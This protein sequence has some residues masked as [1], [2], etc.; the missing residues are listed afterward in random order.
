MHCDTNNIKSQESITKLKNSSKQIK[1]ILKNNLK[2]NIPNTPKYPL[3]S[4][5]FSGQISSLIERVKVLAAYD[6][7]RVLC[8]FGLQLSYAR[9]H[10]H[11]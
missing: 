10:T 6:G 4:N 2:T 7:I 11:A 8:V 1:F 5:A 3:S 9:T